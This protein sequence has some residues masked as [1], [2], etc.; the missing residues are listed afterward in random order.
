MK[1]VCENNYSCQQFSQHAPL[2]MFNRVLSMP[3]FLIVNIPGFWICLDYAGFWICLNSFW[4]CLNMPKCAKI[5]VNVLKSAWIA[6]GLL[7][8]CNPM[9][10]WM[11]G[12]WFQ[13][14]YETKKFS[15]VASFWFALLIFFSSV[16]LFYVNSRP[17]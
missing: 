7:P 4:T 6:L 9:S 15:P 14:L 11:R 1:I 17:V 16:Q 3:R 10:T 2:Y 13:C 8:H 5:C 12:Y